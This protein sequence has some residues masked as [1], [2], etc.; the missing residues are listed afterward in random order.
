MKL[1]E[2]KELVKDHPAFN[3]CSK[4]E[5]LAKK[6]GIKIIFCPKYHCELNPIEGLWCDLK[7]YIRARTDQ[8]Y[9]TMKNLLIESRDK[10]VEKKLHVKLLK[11]FW[12]VLR[13]YKEGASY[14]LVLKTYFSGKSKEKIE[15]HRKITN[16]IL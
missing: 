5:M 15:Q 6:Y 7:Q 9:E 12:R 13:A 4:L 11:R 16:N 1:N 8:K 14:G 10:F 2:I 3:C